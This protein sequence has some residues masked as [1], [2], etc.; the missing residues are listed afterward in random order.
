MSAFH[1][2]F[3]LIDNNNDFIDSIHRD[4]VLLL[5]YP[6]LIQP[7]IPNGIKIFQ[8]HK[9]QIRAVVVSS[10]FFKTKESLD[11]LKQQIVGV[12]L[13]FVS[14]KENIYLKEHF[15]HDRHL[16]EPRSYKEL[17]TVLKAF[18]EK[19]IDLNNIQESH[20]EKFVEIKLQDKDFLPIEIDEF[21][22]LP[23]SHFNVF[24]RIG[25]GNYIK[26][27]N[28]GESG[29]KDVLERYKTKGFTEIF[30][31][32]TEHERYIKLCE[33][34]SSQLICSNDIAPKEKLNSV[35]K[36]GGEVSKSL[37]KVGLE[38]KNLDFAESFLDQSVSLIKNYQI[39]DGN[40]KKFISEIEGNEH[41]AAVSFLAGVIAN[42]LGFESL[43]SVKLVGIAAL[44]HDI[45]L[46][47]L[48]PDADENSL[49]PDSE[50]MLT[51]A[52]HGANLLRK[53]GAFEETVCLA[54]EHHHF[55]RRGGNSSIRNNNMNLIAEI[56]GVA[57][58][59]YNRVLHDGFNPKK[60]EHFVLIE[61]KTFSP[62]IE[63]GFLK[64]LNQ[65]RK[66][67]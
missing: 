29:T 21:L 51:H 11:D 66:A 26:I 10:S 12:P 3:L 42:E 6:L 38:P 5:E 55:R 15:N 61:L 64:I 25:S 59:F 1:G 23:K 62:P 53:S 36:L 28:A 57:D 52:S 31:P 40:L 65:K 18:V 37:L 45:G 17:I 8:K 54:V 39:K 44:V 16:S 47:D 34:L 9:S 22:V 48:S 19:K 63:K 56:V 14:H 32:L 2:K 49:A 13:I 20:D 58:L 60:L 27:V 41:S 30:L 67:G 43:K 24:I 50:I 4:P 35:F 46:H 33:K 7:T